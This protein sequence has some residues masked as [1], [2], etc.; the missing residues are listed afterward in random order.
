MFDKKCCRYSKFHPKPRLFQSNTEPFMLGT[1]S[2]NPLLDPNHVDKTIYIIFSHINT[3][4]V[5]KMRLCNGPRPDFHL[6]SNYDC[7]GGVA[8]NVPGLL[9]LDGRIKY[10]KDESSDGLI[11][12]ARLIKRPCQIER[13]ILI[14]FE[15]TKGTCANFIFALY[16]SSREMENFH[17]RAK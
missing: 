16:R 10:R 13:K 12:I 9:F 3:H 11:I 5:N 1:D 17:I 7:D 6:Y 4:Q 2:I 15:C 14:R 8:R